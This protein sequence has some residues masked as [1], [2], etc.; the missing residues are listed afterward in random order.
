M[1]PDSL[2]YSNCPDSAMLSVCPPIRISVIAFNEKQ[3]RNKKGARIA[4]K[5]VYVPRVD[6]HIGWAVRRVTLGHAQ[7]GRYEVPE[8]IYT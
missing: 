1:S 2:S 3:M 5:T 6:A 4:Y 8:G 7:Q